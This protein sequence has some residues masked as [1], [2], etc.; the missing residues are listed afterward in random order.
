MTAEARRSCGRR[1]SAHPEAGT[2]LSCPVLAGGADILLTSVDIL[3]RRQRQ[4]D[5]LGARPAAPST[6][7]GSHELPRHHAGSGWIVRWRLLPQRVLWKRRR[8]DRR[9][10]RIH[11]TRHVFGRQ[12]EGAVRVAGGRREVA[13]RRLQRL[14]DGGL[15]RRRPRL[16][17]PYNY[18][19][20]PSPSSTPTMSPSP[21]PTPTMSPSPSPSPSPT[22]VA[23]ADLA[24]TVADGLTRS[25]EGNASNT[26][27]RSRMLVLRRRPRRSS[28]TS[29]P[30]VSPSSRRQHLRVRA[31][32][33][34]EP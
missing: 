31:P 5:G 2:S 13:V 7:L 3:R 8:R 14:G 21:S 28:G 15:H 29:S 30:P 27:R 16:V 33:R 10:L 11:H 12:H 17:G 1:I 20:L 24:V 34:T 6:D 23:A 19:L 22:P 26:T 25:R 9:V 18:P 32:K 4:R